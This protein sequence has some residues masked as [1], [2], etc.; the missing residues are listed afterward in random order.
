MPSRLFATALRAG[1]WCLVLGL[2]AVRQAAASGNC[3]PICDPIGFCYCECS[4]SPCCINSCDCGFDLNSSCKCL[5]I[6]GPS[7]ASPN[8]FGCGGVIFGGLGIQLLNNPSTSVLRTSGAHGGAY[9]DRVVQGSPADQAGLRQGDVI[10][11]IDAIRTD[12]SKCESC[13]MCFHDRNWLEATMILSHSQLFMS[14]R[15]VPSLARVSW[16]TFLRLPERVWGKSKN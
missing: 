13:E 10:V 11:G 14:A 6:T 12:I 3:Q 9:I 15:I 5:C 1:Y 4:S 2:L 16:T 8:S 7:G